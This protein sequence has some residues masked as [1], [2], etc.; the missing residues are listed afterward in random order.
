MACVGCHESREI[1]PLVQKRPLAAR[2]EPSKLTPGPTGTWPLRF[3]QLVQPVLDRHCVSCHRP[4]SGNDKA[5]QL[6]LTSARAYDSLHGFSGGDLSKLA[7][8]RPR[9]IP[10]QC[11][12]AKS[13]LLALLK[14]ANGHEGV[15]LDAEGLTRLITW[16]DLYAQRQ[17]SF[18]PAQDEQL[19]RLRETW[20]SMLVAAER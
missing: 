16:M 18:S 2:R 7:H 13:K 12:A 1:T 19:L 4:Q 17:G 3:D 14:D 8:E 10:G 6:D 20:S 9:S 15:R 5:A 11:V